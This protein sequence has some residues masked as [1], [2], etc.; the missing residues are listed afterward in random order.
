MHLEVEITRCPTSTESSSS[1][2]AWAGSSTTTSPR[3][4]AFASF[5]SRPQLRRLGIVRGG[6]IVSDIEAAHVELAGRGIDANEIWHGP[7]FPPEARQLGPDPER[8]SYGWFFSFTDPDGNT[9]LV[10][11]VTTRLPGRIDATG[12]AFASTAD[13]A[14]ALR[15]AEAAH[16][17]HQKRTSRTCCT[18]WAK[19]RTAPPGT[20]PIWWRSR[21]AR[22][23]PRD[24]SRVCPAAAPAAAGRARPEER[25][26][27][28]RWLNRPPAR[29]PAATG[30]TPRKTCSEGETSW[31]SRGRPRW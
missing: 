5:S 16:A 18:G 8:T 13:L 29:G 24:G 11:E 17:E 21:P 4:T 9:W 26:L 7:P 2:S 22:I 23:C 28:K 14:S 31:R 10:Q 3:W 30:P 12:T 1:A 27:G 19:T 25:V 15:R 20:P 6:L